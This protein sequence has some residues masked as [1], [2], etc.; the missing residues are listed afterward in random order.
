MWTAVGGAGCD[1]QSCRRSCSPA[2]RASSCMCSP[3]KNSHFG[4][5][6]LHTVQK[7]RLHVLH[8][9]RRPP[10]LH[11]WLQPWHQT[12]WALLTAQYSK[13]VLRVAI[14]QAFRVSIRVRREDRQR[15]WRSTRWHSWRWSRVVKPVVCLAM[16]AHCQSV[17]KSLSKIQELSLVGLQ[18]ACSSASRR[19]SQCCVAWA[20]AAA[21]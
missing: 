4:A 5:V 21:L 3:W 13:N 15:G 20:A 6:G 19:D 9:Q 8:F 14:V 1:T 12:P 18:L 2:P 11:F 7:R 10:W 16:V 17:P